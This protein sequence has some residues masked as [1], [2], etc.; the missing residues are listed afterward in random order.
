MTSSLGCNGPA[1][2][3][4]PLPHAHRDEGATTTWLSGATIDREARAPS[5]DFR[6]TIRIAL[7]DGATG[8]GF[9]GRGALAVRP[10]RAL[11]MVLLGA[12]GMTAMDV[13][14][15]GDRFRAA[16]PALDRVVRGDATAAPE[17]TRGLP[18]ALLR[19]WMIA[20]FGA[21]TSQRRWGVYARP[22][23]GHVVDDAHALLV[24]SVGARGASESRVRARW[25]DG[26]RGNG[27][28]WWVR[29][30]TVV[31]YL[32]GDE[33]QVT[34]DSIEAVVPTKVEYVSLD[35]PMRAEVIVEETTPL[36]LTGEAAERVFVEPSD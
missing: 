23:D 30:G 15:D 33:R 4:G 9:E 1:L 28:M 16:I 17:T 27:R 31:G 26:D 34:L 36:V 7:R 25:W 13:W 21:G 18:I 8:F 35:P 19:D 3:V 11:R 10:G 24:W 20:P 5:I 12:G 6:Q 32:E 22:V 29:Q 14:I 2:R